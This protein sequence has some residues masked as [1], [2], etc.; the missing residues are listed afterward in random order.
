MPHE[1]AHAQGTGMHAM[2]LTL[3]Q[4]A[5]AMRNRRQGCS[6]Y[7]QNDTLMMTPKCCPYPLRSDWSAKACNEAGECGCMK[8]DRF[9]RGSRR[10][11]NR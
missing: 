10:W 1:Q 8:G 2:S 11:V 5:D 6:F 9:K 3:S 4:R 7:W